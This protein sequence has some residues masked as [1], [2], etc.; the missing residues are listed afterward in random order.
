MRGL[1][2]LFAV[3]LCTRAAANTLTFEIWPSSDPD[4]TT[5][6]TVSL[7]HGRFT[8]LEVRGLGLPPA[9][10]LRW[11]ADRAETSALVQALQSLVSGD[12]ASAQPIITSRLPAPPF[13][14]ATWMATLDTGLASGLYIQPGLTLPPVLATAITTLMPGGLCARALAPPVP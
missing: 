5:S 8:A 6:C 13:I 4:L 14:T 10:T 9:A 11:Y 7:S 1:C 2:A 12:L 3:L